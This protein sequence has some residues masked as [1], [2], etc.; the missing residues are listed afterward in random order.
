LLPYRTPLIVVGKEVPIGVR[1][2]AARPGL[3]GIQV[4]IKRATFK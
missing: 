3:P 1:E 4:H 2:A